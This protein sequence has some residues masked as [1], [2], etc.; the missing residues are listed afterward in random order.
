M[1]KLSKF[2]RDTDFSS[3]RRRSTFKADRCVH[4]RGDRQPTNRSRC[5]QCSTSNHSYRSATI[6]SS[7][8]TTSMSTTSTST[9]STSTTYPAEAFVD[10]TRINDGS[11][12]ASGGERQSPMIG[13]RV[14]VGSMVDVS[15]VSLLRTLET[16]Q[17]SSISTTHSPSGPLS[18]IFQVTPS[19]RPAL[20]HT[21]LST[22]P[23]SL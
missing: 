22:Q 16:L 19:S 4:L 1:G 21:R 7:A 23:H 8:S 13:W 10:P 14:I 11:V 6:P 3:S 15:G 5:S 9:T 2:G 20:H 12:P 17:A 18:F